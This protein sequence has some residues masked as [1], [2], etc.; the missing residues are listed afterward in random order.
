MACWTETIFGQRLN[1]ALSEI[2][3]KTYNSAQVLLMYMEKCRRT[4]PCMEIST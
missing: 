1:V 4:E 3:A 2:D